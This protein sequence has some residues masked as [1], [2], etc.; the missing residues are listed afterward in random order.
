MGSKQNWT[1][2]PTDKNIFQKKES[3]I[4][5]EW[6]ED[7]DDEDNTFILGEVSLNGQTTGVPMDFILYF[8]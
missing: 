6:H 7:D 3:L 1:L 2:D 8:I 4:G 5:L